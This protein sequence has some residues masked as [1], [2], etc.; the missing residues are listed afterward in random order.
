MVGL[1]LL[2]RVDF[3]NDRT[4]NVSDGVLPDL[5]SNHGI[6]LSEPVEGL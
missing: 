4:H 5:D 6:E 1:V 2:A 3:V